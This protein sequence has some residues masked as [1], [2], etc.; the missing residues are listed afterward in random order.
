LTL[1]TAAIALWNAVYLERA[2]AAIWVKGEESPRS[3]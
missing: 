1:L 3:T 2:V